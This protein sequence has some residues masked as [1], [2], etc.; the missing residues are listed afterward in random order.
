VFFTNSSDFYRFEPKNVKVRKI[1]F[2]NSV[3]NTP[4]SPCHVAAGPQTIQFLLQLVS[5]LFSS[6]LSPPFSRI[7]NRVWPGFFAYVVKKPAFGL[8]IRGGG[9]RQLWGA[10]TPTPGSPLKAC[11]GACNRQAL[12]GPQTNR[13][14]QGTIK[15]YSSV[16]IRQWQNLSPSDK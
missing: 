4:F 12:F 1:E 16:G 9:V 6:C 7:K 14:M 10:H 13:Q 15:H 2:L 11:M 8:N 5:E 3:Y